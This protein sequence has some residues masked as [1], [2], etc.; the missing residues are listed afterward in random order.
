[1]SDEIE[2]RVALLV[3]VIV[4]AVMWTQLD[5]LRSTTLTERCAALE[6]QRE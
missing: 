1:M 4:W 5:D 6:E 2:C 3:G